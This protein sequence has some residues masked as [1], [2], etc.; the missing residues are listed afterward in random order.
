MINDQ[1]AVVCMHKVLAEAA[2]TPPDTRAW[3]PAPLRV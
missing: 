2:P 3:E 1:G